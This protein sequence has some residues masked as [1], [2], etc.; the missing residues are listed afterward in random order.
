MRP[1]P[2]GPTGFKEPAS[3]TALPLPTPIAL[4]YG[5]ALLSVVG[6]SGSS[7]SVKSSKSSRPL[8]F[9]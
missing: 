6:E 9:P 8:A 2:F 7:N 1:R 3:S 4:P 5:N